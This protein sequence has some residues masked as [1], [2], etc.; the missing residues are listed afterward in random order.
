MGI[1]EDIQEKTVDTNLEA[2]GKIEEEVAEI[3]KKCNLM[4][5]LCQKAVKDICHMQKDFQ[6]YMCLDIWEMK[7]MSLFIR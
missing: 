6:Y 7:G 2:F 3:L 5:Y 4:R 1:K